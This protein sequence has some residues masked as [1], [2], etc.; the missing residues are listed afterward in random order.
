MQEYRSARFHD[1][2]MHDGYDLHIGDEEAYID[3]LHQH[4]L[5]ML[6]RVELERVK[7]H[8]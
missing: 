4:A 8:Q 3:R 2:T 6:R 5:N 7:A 1:N